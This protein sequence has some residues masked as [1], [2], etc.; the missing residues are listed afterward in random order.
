MANVPSPALPKVFVALDMDEAKVAPFIDAL[1]GLDLGLK[2]GME[3]VFQSGPGLVRDL[4]GPQASRH[5][6]HGAIS[7]SADC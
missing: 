7:G 2:V 4:S 3:L 5:S 6:E 1:D